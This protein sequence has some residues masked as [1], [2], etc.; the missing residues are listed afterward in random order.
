VRELGEELGLK[1]SPDELLD[2]WQITET[3]ARGKNTVTIFVL[4]A[5]REPAIQLDGLELVAG[6]WLTTEVALSRP[7]VSHVRAYLMERG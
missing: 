6:H 5:A 2:P 3:S 1:V 7:L 4:R